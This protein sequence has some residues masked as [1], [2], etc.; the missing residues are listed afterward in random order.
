M[1]V[2]LIMGRNKDFCSC[3][4]FGNHIIFIN[5]KKKKKSVRVLEPN[6]GQVELNG[7]KI[8]TCLHQKHKKKRR[9]RG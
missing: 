9:R 3:L 2:R 8:E 1:V 4:F 5:K 7:R 6:G